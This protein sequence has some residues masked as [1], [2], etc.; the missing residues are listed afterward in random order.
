MEARLVE[1]EIAVVNRARVPNLAVEWRRVHTRY[2]GPSSPLPLR[3]LDSIPPP[4]NRKFVE[5]K[6]YTRYSR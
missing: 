2:V 1:S 6:V 3:P 4:S 5:T